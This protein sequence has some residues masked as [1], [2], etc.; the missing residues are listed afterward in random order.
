MAPPR[1]IAT[2][3]G[4]QNHADE[5]A[6]A[7]LN[8]V[9]APILRIRWRMF[10]FLFGFGFMAYVQ[11]KSITVA[12]DRIM[13]DL[14]VSQ[15]QIGLLEQAFVIG[16]AF[17]QVPGGI[18]GQRFGARRAFTAV[19]LL[20]FLAMTATAVAP[21]VFA[22][23][24][25]FVALLGAQLLLGIAQAAIFPMTAG[26]FGAWFPPARWAF[27]QGLSTMGLQL[28]AAVTPPVVAALMLS[29][30]WQSA[31]FWIS[32][33][34]LLLIGVWAWYA[35]DAPAEHP[36][37]TPVELAEIGDHRSTA[38]DSSVGFARLVQ[39]LANRNVLLIASSYLCMNY[40]FYL[41]SNWVFLYL[42][43]ERH[44]SALES[45]ALAA[46]PPLAAAFGAGLGGILTNSLLPRWGIRW[47]YR[48]VPLC[49]LPTAGVLLFAAVHAANAYLAV[50]ALATCYAAVELTEASY[51][52][53][54]M[55]IG[56]GDTMAV[57]G[58]MNTGGNLGGI[59]GIPIVAY[60]SG[61]HQWNA[62]FVL[63]AGFAFV[64]ALLWL[65]ID[66][67]RPVPAAG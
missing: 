4:N 34:A 67:D 42:I 33:P 18:F 62:A 50:A 38:V 32:A 11:Q 3:I 61:H 46:A 59:V 5:R 6:V 7:M 63:G 12:A 40:V 15:F 23:Q 52:G 16:Y 9:A 20:A 37:M 29:L 51:W 22:A 58:L 36:G 13:P 56:G 39:V 35:R 53:T 64:S 21:W 60:L 49:A 41:L 28:G 45:G 55:A 44:F 19:S 8:P 26:V 54:A 25:V 14:H 57:S 2:T 47:G 1:S 65:L 43:Q 66:A 30:G 10:A 31:L 48:L 17:F 24:A 27:V